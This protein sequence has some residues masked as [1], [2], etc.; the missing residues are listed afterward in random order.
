MYPF[1]HIYTC[2]HSAIYTHV[3][4]LS[5][6]PLPFRLPQ[7]IEQSSLLAL[8]A[9]AKYALICSTEIFEALDAYSSM[10]GTLGH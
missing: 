2:I 5:K 6:T 9:F 4:I 1:S 7:N 8:L 10:L 3:S